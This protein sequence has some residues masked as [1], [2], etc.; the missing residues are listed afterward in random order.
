MWGVGR[1]DQQERYVQLFQLHILKLS[2][3]GKEDC[4]VLLK[5]S[6]KKGFWRRDLKKVGATYVLQ[7]M[8]R[9]FC[10]FLQ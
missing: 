7:G 6:W 5:A 2:L 10:F 8:H 1:S 9:R 3:V 4:G